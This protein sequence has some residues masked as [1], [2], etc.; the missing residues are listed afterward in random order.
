M[1]TIGFRDF[2]LR[3]ITDIIEGAQICLE[4]KLENDMKP[5][6]QEIAHNAAFSI[7]ENFETRPQVDTLFKRAVHI[8]L[9]SHA[10]QHKDLFTYQ[11]LSHIADSLN[12]LANDGQ[13]FKGEFLTTADEHANFIAALEKIK[14]TALIALEYYLLKIWFSFQVVESCAYM[15]S[16]KVNINFMNELEKGIYEDRR[17]AAVLNLYRNYYKKKAADKKDPENTIF[18]EIQLTY[19]LENSLQITKRG[20]LALLSFE[21][22]PFL[23][24]KTIQESEYLSRFIKSLTELS[25]NLYN[26]IQKR[27]CIRLSQYGSDQSLSSNSDK[28]SILVDCITTLNNLILEHQ[29]FAD[30]AEIELIAKN[31]KYKGKNSESWDLLKSVTKPKEDLNAYIPQLSLTCKEILKAVEETL[32]KPKLPKGTKDYDPL[33]MSIKNKVI[34]KIRSIYLKHGAVEIDTPVFELKETLTGKY[35]EEGNKLIYD[36]EDQGGELLSL[37]YD[38]TVPFARYMGLNALQKCKRFHIGKVYRR[39]QPNLNKG[40]FREFYQCD[41]DIAGKTQG[42][43]ADAEALLIMHEIYHSFEIEFKIKISHRLLLE[44]IIECSGCELDKFKT[45]CSSID[46]LDKEPWSAVEKELLTEKGL[47]QTQVDKLKTF[48]LNSGETKQ[49]IDK[50]EQE[51]LFGDN[52]KAAKSLAELREL[53]GFLD[54]FGVNH[55]IVFDLSL[56]RGLDYYTGLIYEAVLVGESGLGSI[57]GGGRYD[58]LIGMF[59]TS[60]IPA[61]GLSIGIERLFIILEQKYQEKARAVETEVLVATIGKGLINHRVEILNLCWK[62]GIK[63]ETLYEVD[64]KPDKQLKQ[65]LENKVPFILW[66]GEDE[67]KKGELKVKCTYTKAEEVVKRENVIERLKELVLKFKD[68]SEKGLVVYPK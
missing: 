9:L 51:Q 5:L 66:I 33:Q 57:G 23:Q 68:D 64:P 29:G 43:L 27:N 31:P 48:V 67:I 8:A 54:I 39:D 59:S 32:K 65:A 22:K 47:N 26:D 37:R 17:L 6:S 16:R 44:A 28:I 53:Q 34:E 56:A 40:R 41:L 55:D 30:Q 42:M 62:N 13:S 58:Y 46:K 10:I 63:A 45:I 15:E 7:S 4:K 24:N 2:N 50:L 11:T 1:I 21:K 61:V 52:P 38:L 20:V 49:L 14:S 25:G 35:G 60:H 36:L 3:Q 19:N 12:S 18:D